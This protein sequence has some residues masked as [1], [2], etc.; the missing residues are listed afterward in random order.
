[1]QTPTIRKAFECIFEQFEGILSIRMQNRDIRKGF[2]AFEYKF[3]IFKG[4]LKHLNNHSNQT[5]SI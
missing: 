4:D 3:E 5:Q 1:M 2:E